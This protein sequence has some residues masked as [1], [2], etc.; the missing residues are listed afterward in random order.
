MKETILGIAFTA[1]STGI[2][3]HLCPESS[4]KKQIS[5]LISS[6]FILSCISFIKDGTEKFTEIS[7]V[8]AE[9]GAYADFSDEAYR[10]TQEEIAH[11]L[12]EVISEKL[13]E[14]Q[15][16][17]DEIHVI[18]DISSEYSISI[19]QVRLAFAVDNTDYAA[20]AEAL[21]KKEVGNEI[22]VVIEFKSL[23]S[24]D[25]CVNF[26]ADF[27]ADKAKSRRLAVAS[28]EILTQSAAKY[29]EKTCAIFYEYTL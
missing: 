8:F 17:C 1:I 12:E 26:R 4:F 21:V 27:V 15:I 11:K 10:M 20:A 14:N 16:L 13:K 28:R 19:K 24:S 23:Y 6:F 25:L 22:E 29:A 5:L 7:D 9:R 2:F 18:V 3:R